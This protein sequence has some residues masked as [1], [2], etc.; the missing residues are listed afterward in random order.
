M[1]LILIGAPGVGKGSQAELISK[2]YNIPHISTGDMIRDHVK[3]GSDFGLEVKS[4]MDK[5]ELVPDDLIIGMLEKRIESEKNGYILDGFP[6]T[7]EQAKALEKVAE[8]TKVVLFDCREEVIVQRLSGRRV[9]SKC[10]EIYH[11]EFNPPQEEGKCDH[12]GEDLFQRNDDKPETIKNRLKVYDK[13]TKPL[14]DFYEEKGLLI[15]INAE[16][17]KQEIFDDTIDVLGE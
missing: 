5:G 16:R 15:K 6:R 10:G 17:S 4:Y 8:I 14:I 1:N 13:Q 11:I 7:I 3:T 9:C 12:D 2:K